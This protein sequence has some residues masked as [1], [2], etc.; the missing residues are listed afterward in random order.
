LGGPPKTGSFI[1]KNRG[2]PAAEGGTKAKLVSHRRR[3]AVRRGVIKKGVCSKKNVR[4]PIKGGGRLK[5][6]FSAVLQ[7]PLVYRK[8]G[9][10][11]GPWLRKTGGGTL[12]QGQKGATRDNTRGSGREPR[13]SPRA[14]GE[15]G[16]DL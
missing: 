12:L 2:K 4:H 3:N 14:T 8:R 1:A 10:G 6:P 13:R 15:E 11:G 5:N 9:F 16:F 7:A